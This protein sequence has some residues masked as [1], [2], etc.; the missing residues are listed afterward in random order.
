MGL[1]RCTPAGWRQIEAELATTD[2]DALQ[3]TELLQRLVARGT[4]IATV[5]VDGGWC[6]VDSTSDLA[7]YERCLVRSGWRHD[8][9]HGWSDATGAH[10]GAV[11]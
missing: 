10:G 1:L 9:R 2:A 7:L 11:A 3:T 5:P 4:R 8:W 6:E